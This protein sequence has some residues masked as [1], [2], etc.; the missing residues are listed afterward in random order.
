MK[1]VTEYRINAQEHDVKHWQTQ[2]DKLTKEINDE[3]PKVDVVKFNMLE[4]IRRILIEQEE[5]LEE[6][7][8]SIE[9]IMKTQQDNSNK[10]DEVLDCLKGNA[11]GGVGLVKDFYLLNDN[12]RIKTKGPIYSLNEA[13]KNIW[14]DTRFEKI[15]NKFIEEKY[16]AQIS[17]MDGKEENIKFK[18]IG[19][20]H[21]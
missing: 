16:N 20:A 14:L 7:E 6:M 19:R 10:L 12:L 15:I 18:Q 8:T 17:I 21:V 4:R 5:K 13:N 3:F 2:F 11:M 9:Q 1:E